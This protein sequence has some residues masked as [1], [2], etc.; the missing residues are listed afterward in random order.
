MRASPSLEFAFHRTCRLVQACLGREAISAR[1]LVCGM[2]LEILGVDV[3]IKTEGISMSPSQDK[4]LKWATR[5]KQALETNCLYPGEASKLSGAL[6]WAGQRAF[7]RLGRAMLL[8]IRRQ[9][10]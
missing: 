3:V 5:I 10:W 7:R 2:P 4:K 8:P 6:A 9:G 1:K